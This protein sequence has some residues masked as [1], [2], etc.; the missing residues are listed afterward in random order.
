MSLIF[1]CRVSTKEQNLARQLARAKEVNATKVFIDKLSGKNLNRTEFQACMKYLR[2][3]DTLEIISLDRLSRNYDDI[4]KVVNQLKEKK[5]K[6]VVDDLPQTDTGNDLVD[7]FMLDMMVNLMGFV[8]DNERQKI[9]ERTQQGIE[10]AKK[11]G[12]YKGK[13]YEYSETARDRGKRAIFND[14]KQAYNSDTYSVSALAKKHDIPR[15]TVYRIIKQIK[16]N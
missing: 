15:S 9:L 2:E 16:E 5:V 11:R 4:Q 7:K 1:Y 8:A 6:L 13:Q 12:V 14:I 10:Q 3:N